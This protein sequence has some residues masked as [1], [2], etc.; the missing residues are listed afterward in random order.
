MNL[1]NLSFL[2]G[3]YGDDTGNYILDST[4]EKVGEYSYEIF[5]TRKKQG[6]S[7]GMY[8]DRVPLPIGDKYPLALLKDIRINEDRRR[9]GFATQGI[10]EFHQKATQAGCRLG[11]LHVGWGFFDEPSEVL[12]WK[13]QMFGKQGWIEVPQRNPEKELFAMYRV[14]AV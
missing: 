4:G 1:L 2:N 8:A 10:L 5:P 14:F 13:S 6:K 3:D 11:L 7:Y 12:S 9:E